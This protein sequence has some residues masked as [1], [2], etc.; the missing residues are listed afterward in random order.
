MQEE[1]TSDQMHQQKILKEIEDDG[2][3]DEEVRQQEQSEQGGEVVVIAHGQDLG[4]P[5]EEHQLSQ[6][7]KDQT[8]RGGELIGCTPIKHVQSL[9][10]RGRECNWQ[11]VCKW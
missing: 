3:E 6:Q 5:D 9:A 11:C 4:E 1:A 10:W 8:G 7:V 2:R